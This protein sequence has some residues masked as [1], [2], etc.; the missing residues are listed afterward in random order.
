MTIAGIDF[1]GDV[2]QSLYFAQAFLEKVRLFVAG[3]R[4]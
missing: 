2:R 3:C 1:D 4:N